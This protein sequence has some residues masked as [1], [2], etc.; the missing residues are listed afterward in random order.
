M[1]GRVAHLELFNLVAPKEELLQRA[2][3]VVQVLDRLPCRE[4]VQVV[5]CSAQLGTAQKDSHVRECGWIPAQAL[6][7]WSAFPALVNR[8]TPESETQLV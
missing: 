3:E 8:H 5:L 4:S 2:S 1:A 6:S 7:T